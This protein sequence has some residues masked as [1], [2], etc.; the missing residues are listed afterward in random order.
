MSRVIGSHP[1]D[2]PPPPEPEEGGFQTSRVV[3]LAGGHAVHDSFTAFLPRL[4]PQFIDKFSLS[5]TAAGALS[6]VLG[7]PGLLQWAIGHL[8]DRTTLRWV[9]VMGPAVTSILMA[10]LGWAPT[11]AVLAVML[12]FAGISVAAFHATAPVAAGRLSGRQLGKG[13]G[14]WMVGGELGRT[15][16]P[17]VATAGLTYLTLKQMAFLA[18]AGVATS[19]VLHFRLRGVSLRTHREGDRIPWRSA[20]GGMRRL[21][22]ILAGVMILRSLMMTATSLFLVVYLTDEGSSPWVAGAALSIFEGAGVVGALSGGWVSDHLGRRTVVYASQIGAP[23]ALFLFLAT[24]G[25]LRIA[26]LPLVGLTLLSVTPVFMAMVQ[27]EFPDS[28]A[29]ANGTY[30]SVHYAIRTVATVGFGAL[31]D[32]FGLTTA[33]AISGFTMLGAIPLVWLLPERHRAARAR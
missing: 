3:T 27:E 1:S 24:D 22:T 14:L 15:V 19:A 30:L 29:L 2:A 10:S 13:M 11:Y 5:N 32:A 16:G 12:F 18:V 25:W 6:S 4:L 33:M 20:V 8:A 28:R 26:V 21:M 17:L 9:V 7:L 23:L 31:G